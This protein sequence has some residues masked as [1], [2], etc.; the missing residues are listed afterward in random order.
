MIRS[1]GAGTAKST[2]V[3]APTSASSRFVRRGRRNWLPYILA[4][5]ILAYE[6]VFILY[7]IG[8]GMASSFTRTDVGRPVTFV[9]LSN[10]QRMLTDPGFWVVMLHTLV[11]MVAV[12]GVSIGAGLAS[13]LLFNRPFVGRAF[14]RGLLTLPWSFP[15]VPTV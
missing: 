8:Q 10:Y 3:L 12:I 15:D 11:Y 5:P 2:A 9:G 6:A 4:L 14:A 13:A 7:P 1:P